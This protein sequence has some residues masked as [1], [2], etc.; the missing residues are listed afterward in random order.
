MSSLRITVAFAVIVFMVKC[1]TESKDALHD[2]LDSISRKLA[3]KH[4]KLKG[5]AIDIDEEIDSLYTLYK[6]YYKKPDERSIRVQEKKRLAFADRA[7][8]VIANNAKHS[9]GK[10]EAFYGKSVN[11]LRQPNVNR[12]IDEMNGLLKIQ[13]DLPDSLDWR[14]RGIISPVKDQGI[15]GSCYA[16][17]TIGSIE[18]QYKLM[19]NQSET[20]SEQQIVDC[21][22][23]SGNYGCQG[24]LLIST[25]EYIQMMGVTSSRKYPYIGKETGTCSYQIS[26]A[27]ALVIH[28]HSITPNQE[29]KI[30]EALQFG[31]VAV[32][33]DGSASEFINY[34]SGIY[35]GPCDATKLNH[36][37]LLI[38]YGSEENCGR[39]TD[40]W[41]IKNSFGDSWGEDGYIRIYRNGKNYCGVASIPAMALAWKADVS[42]KTDF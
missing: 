3:M 14:Q 7:R 35:D 28:Y 13:M 29:R 20:F 27:V 33:I 18:A 23:W 40:Y 9:E 26:D 10:D 12:V 36:A 24:G 39:I 25:Y 1:A 5:R 22:T 16:F 19:L 4:G 21:S 11:G 34:R 31:P 15:C 6:K 2:Y 32:G 41:L 8:K 30:M 42:S 17:T 37:V 38:G